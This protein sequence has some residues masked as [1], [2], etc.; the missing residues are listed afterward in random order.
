[1]AGKDDR[2]ES[3]ELQV[4]GDTAFKFGPKWAEENLEKLR[5]ISALT[6]SIIRAERLNR[7][8]LSEKIAKKLY[9]QRWYEGQPSWEESQLKQLFMNYALQIMPLIPNDN[10]ADFI[11]EWE[12]K[13]CST[14]GFM[15]LVI[16]IRVANKFQEEE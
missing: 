8:D 5:F 9:A 15:H 12:C 13:D 1:M 10:I 6:A 3:Y 16:P 2:L 11:K 7:P 4:I 14:P